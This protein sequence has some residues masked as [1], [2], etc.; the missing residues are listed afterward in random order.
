MIPCEGDSSRKADLTGWSSIAC[1]LAQA[2]P[3][4]QDMMFGDGPVGPEQSPI[5][6]ID[7]PADFFQLWGDLGQRNSYS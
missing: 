3:A 1:V 4:S 2:P 5:S 6:Q 7:G